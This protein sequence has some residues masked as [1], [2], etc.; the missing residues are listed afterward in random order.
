MSPPI[1]VDDN[2]GN[3][4]TIYSKIDL[5]RLGLSIISG[6]LLTASFPHFGLFPLAFIALV[7]L[8]TAIR[9]LSWFA[10]FRIGLLTG[11]VHY[12]T[13]S[14]WLYHTMNTYGGL[15]WYISIPLMFLISFYLALYIA[16]FSVSLCIFAR[17]SVI[18]LIM[19]PFLWVGLEYIRF[20]FLSGLPWSLLGYTQYKVLHLIQI[21]DVTGI[22][23]VSFIIAAVNGIIFMGC[24]TF[25][26]RI[27]FG[28]EVSKPLTFTAVTSGIV[29]LGLTWHYGDIRLKRINKL[30]DQ[31]PEATITVVQG[32]IDQSQKWDRRLQQYV[33]KK[34]VDLSIKA[35]PSPTDLIVW[36][37]TATP[38]YFTYDKPL[39][40]LVINGIKKAGCDFLIGSPSFEYDDGKAQYYNS[41]FLVRSNG[42][43]AGKYDKAHLVP[44]GEYVPLKKWLFFM[45]KI[46]EH[47]GDFQAGKKGKT[48]QWKNTRLGILICFEVIFPDLARASAKNG[49]QLLINLTN[50]A[51]YGKT[52]APYQH[53]SMAVL[54]AVEN[55][56]SLVRSANTGIS[57]FIEPTGKS[58]GETD[59]Y[60]HTTAT[61]NVS[62]LQIKSFYTLYGDV[63]ARLCMVVT[64]LLAGIGCLKRT[65][66]IRA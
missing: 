52:S 37:E 62:L 10:G 1:A 25:S 28:K 22:Y 58:S 44:F 43:I 2:S 13:L 16:A 26:N 18:C 55:R 50:D 7:P 29:L 4:E 49:A 45:G 57:G 60:I 27:W 15:P 40:R 56:R 35:K 34:Y 24:L 8:L 59:I 5:F 36:P 63:F 46:V 14:Y 3:M 30:M 48:L 33:T 17:K 6:L 38:F 9:G 65:N 64:A 23:G 41:A 19:I 31:S 20:F 61:Q 21:S 42:T 12:I 53:F 54:R 39:T 66:R 11:L 47:V 51:W 32:N